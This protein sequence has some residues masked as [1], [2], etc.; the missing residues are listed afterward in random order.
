MPDRST[1]PYRADHVGSFLRPPELAEAVRKARDGRIDAAAFRAAQDQA[2]RD[3]VAFQEGLGLQSITDGEFRRRGW[4]AGFIDAVAGYGLRDGALG[5]RDRSG[6]IGVASSPYAKARIRRSKPIVA[7]EFRFLKSV[8]RR[9]AKTTIP[10]PPVMHYFLGPRTIDP[11]VYPDMETY[12]A[13]LVAIYRAEIADLAAAGCTYLQLDDT[14]LACHCDEH[15]RADVTARGEDPAAL[16]AR[17]ARLINDAIAGR[18][19][20]MTVAIHLCRGNLKGA[21]M[22]EGGYEPVAETLFNA[23]AA[24]AYFLEY[25]DA[26]AGDFAPLRHVPAPMAVVLGLVSTKT[27]VLEGKDDLKR[28]IDAA[29]RY[30]PLERL[31]LSPQ[32]GFSSAP[33]SGQVVTHDDERRKLDLI[34]EVARE[35]WG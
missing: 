32:C 21:W 19:K 7:E 29:S 16:L 1:P 31:C 20:S 11:D 4:S 26:R 17:Y 28:R 34:L 23:V 22:A 15:V 5:F 3:V 25:D 24:D 18:P 6:V 33:G 30:V 35:V 9:T 2:I 27:P 12:F 8:T 14:A 13:D 10:S